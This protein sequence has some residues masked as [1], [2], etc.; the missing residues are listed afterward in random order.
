M[1]I[2]ESRYTW[3]FNGGTPAPVNLQNSNQRARIGGFTMINQSNCIGGVFI[4]RSVSGVPD[5]QILPTWMVA[6]PLDNA[7]F[8]IIAWVIPPG[9]VSIGSAYA[10]YTPDTVVSSASQV[11]SSASAAGI[12]DSGVWDA[13]LFGA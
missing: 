3:V 8:L 7:P 10:H 6:F 11:A 12:W 4:G 2:N 5:I 1:P 9:N 13:S